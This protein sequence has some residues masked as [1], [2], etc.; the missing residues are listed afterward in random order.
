MLSPVVI[1][2]ADHPTA[3]GTA[4]ALRRM[5]ARPVRIVGVCRNPQAACCR[6]SA[7]D[8]LVVVDRD[9]GTEVE[10]L[11]ELARSLSG[12]ALLVPTNDLT[13]QAVSRE[14]ER[15]HDRYDFVLPDPET[16][17]LLLDKTAFH[18]WARRNGFPV[19]E[20]AVVASSAELDLALREL[21]FPVV[22]K[23]LYRTAAWQRHSPT[24]KVFRLESRADLEGLAIDPFSLAPR[25]I[26]QRWIEGRDDDVFFCL[27]YFDRSGRCVATYTGRKLLQWPPEVGN[28]AICEG[29]ADEELRQLTLTMFERVGFRG[30]GSL[31]V[32]RDRT[33]GK[34]Y[35]VEPTVGRNNLQSFVAVAGGVNLTEAAWRDATGD[36]VASD[37]FTPRPAVWLQENFALRALLK[38]VR[39]RR[40]PLRALA[41]AIRGA[42]ALAC[43][44]VARKDVRPLARLALDVALR[45]SRR[46]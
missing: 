40:L 44:H 39:E 21:A 37:G 6:S 45:R 34:L 15:L 26:V 46:R 7:W 2:G 23:P 32:K 11:L 30:L 10:A 36:T 18:D 9:P 22:L 19:P 13:V 31:E 42:E 14:R 16:V 4:R 43:A 29:I 12:R 33:S 41:G 8:D 3:L 25:L 27:T 20:A 35:I 17:D 28:T 24:A 5:R 1:V 38:S